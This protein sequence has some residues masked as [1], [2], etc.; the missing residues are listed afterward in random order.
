MCHSSA[1]RVMGVVYR[2]GINGAYRAS[3][4]RILDRY[5]VREIVWP[6]AI[7]LVAFTFVLEIPPILQQAEP[8]IS[9]GVEWP[10]IG[11]VL[12]TLLPQA[13]SLT[14]PV[15]VLLGILVG[16]ARM[17]ADRELVAMQACG[18]SLMR[19]FRPIALVATLGTAATAY[20]VIVALPDANQTFRTI[21]FGLVKEKVENNVKP[22][23][24]F[25]E[26]PN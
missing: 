16:L 26:F 17:S 2:E 25:D 8:L 23:V 11:R 21:A 5:L 22:H 12:L 18:V 4:I 3:V 20:E 14:I 10:I 15:A 7:S 1:T 19:L 6:F 24:F 9:R 13:L